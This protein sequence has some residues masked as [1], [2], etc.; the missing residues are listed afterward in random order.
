[1]RVY[2]AFETSKR[3]IDEGMTC[4]IEFGGKVIA[5]VQV[6]P[7]DPSLN[8]DYRRELAAEALALQ[9]SGGI[10]DLDEDTDRALLFKVYARTVIRSW[11][12]IDPADKKDPNLKF[13]EKNAVALFKRIPKFF[14]AIQRG[15]RNWDQFRK[16]HEADAAG[17]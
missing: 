5:K 9:G 2:E 11:E 10:D 7:A 16:V 4:E 1:V 13:N 12:F 6:G 14:E 3:L 15:A 8:A 17:N